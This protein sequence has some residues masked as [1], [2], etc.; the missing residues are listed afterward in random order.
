MPIQ[1]VHLRKVALIIECPL[2]LIEPILGLDI[3]L[4]QLENAVTTYFTLVATTCSKYANYS[5]FNI[6]HNCVCVCVCF[7]GVTY[8]TT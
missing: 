5:R 7:W 2:T 3:D 4:D 6:Q 1:G 8:M